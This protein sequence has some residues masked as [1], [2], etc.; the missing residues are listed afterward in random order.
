VIKIHGIT[1]EMV[2]DAPTFA[3]AWGPMSGMFS[4]NDYIVAHNAP[5]DVSLLEFEFD[6]LGIT[7]FM[8]QAICTVQEYRHVFGHRPKLVE[9][10]KHYV[11]K[12]YPHKH[13]A[14][15]DTRALLEALIAAKFFE[16]FKDLKPEP[17]LPLDDML[18]TYEVKEGTIIRKG[19]MVSVEITSTGP[20]VRPAKYLSDAHGIATDVPNPDFK[21]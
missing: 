21:E 14:I 16:S 10:Y 13:R 1:D 17:I 5:F 4:C 2:K 3:Q 7:V 9:L 18:K 12:E 19:Q 6:R 11:G 15:D 20:V 8:P